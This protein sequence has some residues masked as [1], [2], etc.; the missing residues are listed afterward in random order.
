MRFS[1]RS[2]Y[3]IRAM[4]VLADRDAAGP[5]PLRE[6]AAVE[7]I[8]EQFLEQIFVDLRRAGFVTSVRGAHGGYRLAREPGEISLA[9]L[10]SVLEGGIAPFECVSD[11]HLQD[12]GC[13]RVDSCITRKVWLRLKETMT[14]TLG[15]MTLADLRRDAP[16]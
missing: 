11:Q 1:F 3:G 7:N 13:D 2:E 15:G 6:I 16:V 4:G 5:M 8:S 12:D 9:E 10:V 14:E